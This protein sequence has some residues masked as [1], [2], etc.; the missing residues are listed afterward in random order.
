MTRKRKL[1][2][3]AL[4][5]KTVDAANEKRGGGD[6]RPKFPTELI[7][8]LENISRLPSDPDVDLT[9]KCLEEVEGE[10]ETLL[11]FSEGCLL[12]EKIFGAKKAAAFEFLQRLERKKKSQRSALIFN[13]T[14]G[15]TLEKLFV[16]LIPIEARHS[17]LLNS[18]LELV[19][20]EWT[21]VI[22]DRAAAFFVRA[23]SRALCGLSEKEIR[24]A[25]L[26]INSVTRPLIQK[27]IIRAFDFQSM[28]THLNIPSCSL[29]LQ[30]LAAIEKTAKTGAVREFVVRFLAEEDVEK[31][32]S[33][34]ESSRFWEAVLWIV[35]DELRETIFNSLEDRLQEFASHSHANFP[36]QT[37]LR[38]SKSEGIA[39]QVSE[40]FVPE[41]ASLEPWIIGAVLE[42]V[43][44]HEVLQKEAMEKLMEVFGEENFLLNVLTLRDGK[45]ENAKLHGSL[46]LD[47]LFQFADFD[48]LLDFD[49][50]MQTQ[51]SEQKIASHVFDS[52]VRSRTIPDAKK[53]KIFERF[54]IPR[55][56]S[57]QYGTRVFE[58]FW[59]EVPI[60]HERYAR[61]LLPML[62]Q[63]NK[64]ASILLRKLKIAEYRENPKK[65]NSQLPKEIKEE[66]DRRR[67]RPAV[68]LKPH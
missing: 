49:V 23:L 67:K 34:A 36:L 53:L 18:W 48:H 52:L 63:N 31:S 13:S 6:G 21:Y 28:K 39:Q 38:E 54:D 60:Q 55:L 3:E 64:F 33:L 35:D 15:R 32:W 26:R 50:E 7:R 9:Q 11:R 10:E 45:L 40:I 19:V 8:Y 24:K 22:F 58:A 57:N 27:L 14:S 16:A 42:C 62:K 4:Q 29:I 17:E 41:F 1:P 12:V 47:Q 46:I 2:V 65:W 30:D 61:L 68:L 44:R 25:D 43:G 20:D 37:L 5:P 59:F 56:C 66:L 51:M